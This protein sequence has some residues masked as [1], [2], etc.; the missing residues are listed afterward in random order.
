MENNNKNI[1]SIILSCVMNRQ[2]ACSFEFCFYAD[3][4][5]A[6]LC[7]RFITYDATV[8]SDSM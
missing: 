4:S 1:Y 7:S 5:I 8:A 3:L 2:L 6:C